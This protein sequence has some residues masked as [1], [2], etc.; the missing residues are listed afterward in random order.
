MATGDSHHEEGVPLP[1]GVELGG[2]HGR[3]VV[4]G[5]RRVLLNL[6]SPRI[7]LSH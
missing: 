7:V 1:S 6:H 2:S 4:G 5:F 3:G